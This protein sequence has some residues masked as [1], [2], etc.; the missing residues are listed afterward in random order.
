MFVNFGNFS[1]LILNFQV[2]NIFFRLKCILFD[3]CND[4][5]VLATSAIA[6]TILGIFGC[7]YV[8]IFLLG[9]TSKFIGTCVIEK[10]T[11]RLNGVAFTESQKLLN[12]YF[13]PTKQV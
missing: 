1:C 10:D 11:E 4:S 7:F 8:E 9:V 2:I 3:G 6:E 5:E 13:F 12:F